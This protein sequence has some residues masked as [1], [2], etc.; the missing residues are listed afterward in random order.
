MFFDGGRGFVTRVEWI[1]GR[2]CVIEV[3]NGILSMAG[4]EEQASVQL[5]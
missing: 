4:R 3:A 1:G 2:C 5:A